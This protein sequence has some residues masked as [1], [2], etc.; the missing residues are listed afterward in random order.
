MEEAPTYLVDTNRM[1]KETLGLKIDKILKKEWAEQLQAH[2]VHEEELEQ[3]SV[4]ERAEC[5]A[6]YPC[7]DG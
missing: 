2:R 7:G 5:D 3:A 1:E 6:I 4:L